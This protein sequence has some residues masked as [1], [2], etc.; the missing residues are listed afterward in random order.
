MQFIFTGK[1][2]QA[3]SAAPRH[4]SMYYDPRSTGYPYPESTDAHYLD[5]KKDNGLKFDSSYPFLD[6]SFSFRLRRFLAH[7]ALRCLVFPVARVRLGLRIRG[8]ENLRKHRD[9]LSGGA[10]T[11]AN[12]VHMWDYIAVMRALR[13]RWPHLLVWAPNVRGENGT[14]IRSVGGIPI[15]EGS[16]SGSVAMV[17]SVGKCLDG[18]YVHIYPEGSMWELYAPIRPFKRGTA[19]F[20]CKF[21]KPI[22]PMAFSYRRPGWLRRTVFHQEA[23]FTLTIGEPLLPNGDLP[24]DQREIDLTV[25]CHDAVC[26]L[27]GIDPEENLYPPIY[28]NSKRVD[29]YTDTYGLGY[30]GS[31]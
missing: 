7:A 18:G 4:R 31:W 22:L 27:A 8:R 16:L 24:L 25:R 20:A 26:R 3:G 28:D 9:L 12:H 5:V 29:Y 19:Y 6:N 15:P 11:C 13:P 14:M 17:S 1:G 30:K 2:G 23:L 21:D 10:M